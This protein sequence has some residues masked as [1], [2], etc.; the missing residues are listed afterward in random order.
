MK[1]G[2][3]LKTFTLCALALLPRVALGQEIGE[4]STVFNMIGPDHK[5]KVEA[6]SDPSIKGIK[7]FLS[8]PIT[9]GLA[10][11]VGIAEDKSDVSIS[12]RQV[13][14]IEVTKKI[15]GGKK[16][17]EVFNESRSF[18]FKTLH[19]QR[20]YDADTTSFVYLTYSDKLI[21]GSPKNSVSVVTPQETIGGGSIKGMEFLPR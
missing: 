13:G 10:G 7:C 4:V 19:V 11:A 9:G 12:C 5:I 21:E 14:P 17:E 2:R 16:G 18:L 6:F 20:F 8:R 3:A 15:V 1:I